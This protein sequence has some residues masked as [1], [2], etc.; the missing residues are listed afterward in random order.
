MLQPRTTVKN[1]WKSHAIVV[2]EPYK[3]NLEPLK[4]KAI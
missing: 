3:I 1:S 4:S 2:H